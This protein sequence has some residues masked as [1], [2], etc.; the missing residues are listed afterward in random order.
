M[1][2]AEITGS[3]EKFLAMVVEKAIPRL[4]VLSG[5]LPAGYDEYDPEAGDDEEDLA[6]A[7]EDFNAELLAELRMAAR[8]RN[9]VDDYIRFAVVTGA[10][11]KAEALLD[12]VFNEYPPRP[13]WIEI[14]E[15]L[16]VSAQAAHRKYGKAA[17]SRQAYIAASREKAATDPETAPTM[18]TL[19]RMNRASRTTAHDRE[20]LVDPIIQVRRDSQAL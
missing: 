11:G 16:D 15:A 8:L 7:F 9:A 2:M 5:E 17:R 1:L 14:G 4:L 6:A 10:T 3:I 19:N 18:A 13:T 12:E 20:P